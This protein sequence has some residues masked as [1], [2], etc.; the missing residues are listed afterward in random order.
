MVGK[1]AVRPSLMP[2]GVEHTFRKGTPIIT[3]TKVRPSLMP[4]GVEHFR[5]PHELLEGWS[6]ATL[7]DAERR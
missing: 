4:K 2:K 3:L 1:R 6:R 7:F 5:S